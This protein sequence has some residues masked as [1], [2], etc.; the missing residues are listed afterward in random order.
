[1]ASSKEDP[2]NRSNPSIQL[3]PKRDSQTR[4]TTPPSISNYSSFAFHL[5]LD[6]SFSLFKTKIIYIYFCIPDIWKFSTIERALANE[7]RKRVTCSVPGGGD[8]TRVSV[9]I[10]IGRLMG[11][12]RPGGIMGYTHG[13]VVCHKSDT[14]GRGSPVTRFIRQPRVHLRGT[15]QIVSPILHPRVRR[16]KP[17]TWWYVGS[18]IGKFFFPS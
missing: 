18:V 2:E 14:L 15:S 16:V 4:T 7:E 11:G 17:C 1:M 12:F 9:G 10:I 6:P 13:N 3:S 5:F 8:L